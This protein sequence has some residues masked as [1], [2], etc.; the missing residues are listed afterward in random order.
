MM[1]TPRGGRPGLAEHARPRSLG[2]WGA[3]SLS[4]RAGDGL[5]RPLAAM[6]GTAGTASEGS[7]PQGPGGAAQ[8]RAFG[9]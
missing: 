9:V 5:L 7:W 2:G 3:A 1:S 8:G 4:E 6:A